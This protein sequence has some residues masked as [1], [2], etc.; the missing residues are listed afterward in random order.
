MWLGILTYIVPILP[1]IPAII[2]GIRTLRDKDVQ[3]GERMKAI[4]GMGLA[5]FFVMCSVALV[6]IGL[7]SESG[8]PSEAARIQSLRDA[9]VPEDI[10]RKALENERRKNDTSGD[11]GEYSD[12][13]PSTETANGDKTFGEYAAEKTLYMSS[14]DR[15]AIMFWLA[16]EGLVN[17]KMKYHP[18]QA[19]K[20]KWEVKR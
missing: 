7:N 19:E 2:F 4:I 9:G 12:Y 16:K 3:K 10:I 18:A 14:D 17:K 11:S 8:P 6:V 5:S 13:S 20:L 1:V 15:A